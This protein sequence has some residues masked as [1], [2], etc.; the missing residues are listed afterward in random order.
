M[1]SCIC[2]TSDEENVSGF[3]PLKTKERKK[4]KKKLNLSAVSA[5][6]FTSSVV[7]IYKDAG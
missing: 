3:F 4:K 5:K 6:H 7:L 1:W 2:S